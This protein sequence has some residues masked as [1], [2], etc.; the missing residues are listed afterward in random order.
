MKNSYSIGTVNIPNVRDAKK[1]NFIN[2]LDEVMPTLQYLLQE[3]FTNNIIHSKFEAHQ[4]TGKKKV[5]F[6]GFRDKDLKKECEAKGYK[7]VDSGF[8]GLTYLV[9]TDPH[10]TS[11]KKVAKALDK[12]IEVIS[13]K[14]FEKKVRG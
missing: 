5:M 11:K 13:R 7:V 8:K 6:T 4:D 9:A 3:V 10:D 14:E 12:G 2:G 1:E